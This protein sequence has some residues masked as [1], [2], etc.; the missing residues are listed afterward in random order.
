[1]IR[2]LIITAVALA[3]AACASTTSSSAGGAASPTGGANVI[4]SG[5][6]PS[7]DPRVGLKAGWFDAGEAA[8]NMRLISNVRPSKDFLNPTTPG[9]RRL[10]NSDLAFSKNFVIQGNYSG[11]QVWDVS[12]PARVTLKQAYV[13]PGSQSDVSVFRN[14]A[15]VS[16]E[17][18]SGRLDCGLQGVPDS[19]SKDR[20]RGIRVF[21]ITDIAKPKYLTNVQ[22]CRGSHTHTVVT[23]P[24]DPANVYIYV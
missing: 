13:C 12:N 4:V 15:F 3:S 17:A 2:P 23:S 22:T 11:Y 14:L 21:D 9:D 8:W 6:K 20:L 5:T 24:N 10:I 7:P 16:G 19:V 18:T 1:M